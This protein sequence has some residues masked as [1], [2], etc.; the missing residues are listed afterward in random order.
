[1]L[2][3][4]EEPSVIWAL[5]AAFLTHKPP[6]VQSVVVGICVGCFATAAVESND[7][8]PT[9]AAS[10][11]LVIVVGLVAGTAF[12]LGLRAQRRRES[13]GAPPPQ[14]TT[15]TYVVV[16]VLSIA[17][18]VL[19]LFGDGGLRVA[20]LTVVPIV[21]LAPTALAGLRLA[22]SGAKQGLQRAR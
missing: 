16:W 8:D 21:L 22:L 14:W 9:V 4:R 15:V 2:V 1:V 11:S 10:L 5:L 3:Q 13:V 19:A 6:W 12:Y 18:A 17:A 20:L 7:R